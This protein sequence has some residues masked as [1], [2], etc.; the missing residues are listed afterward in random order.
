MSFESNQTFFKQRVARRIR[1]TIIPHKSPA[2]AQLEYLLALSPYYNISFHEKALVRP[3]Y[4]LI[5][6]VRDAVLLIQGVALALASLYFNRDETLPLLGFSLVQLGMMV[7]DCALAVVSAITFI[8]GSI[9]SM[10][11]GYNGLSG[12][13]RI[14]PNEHGQPHLEQLLD[15]NTVNY[16]NIGLTLTSR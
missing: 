15:D 8:T 1:Q 9:M 5:N 13:D 7:V 3:L 12:I 11:K 14:V 2:V 16:E 6:L 4:H 10:A